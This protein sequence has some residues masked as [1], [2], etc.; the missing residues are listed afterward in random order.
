MNFLQQQVNGAEFS[1][2]PAFDMKAFKADILKE[3]RSE[4]TKAKNEIIDGELS[5]FFLLAFVI[6]ARNLCSCDVTVD[7]IHQKIECALVFTRKTL[8]VKSF[9]SDE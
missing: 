2:P 7:V 3:M 5:V 4:I 6:F 8:A 1:L 9:R